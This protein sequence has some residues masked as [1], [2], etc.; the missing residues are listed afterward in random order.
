MNVSRAVKVC[1]GEGTNESMRD[2][3]Q[4]HSV[5]VKLNETRRK[6]REHV[7]RMGQDKLPKA[8]IIYKP[9][10]RILQRRYR[11]RCFSQKFEQAVT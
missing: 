3:F 1:T 11:K 10:G 7:S 6:G 9:R 2:K 5:N 8:I 4:I